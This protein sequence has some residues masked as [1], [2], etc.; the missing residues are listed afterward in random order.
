MHYLSKK[1]IVQFNKETIDAHGGNFNP[2]FN[3]LHEENL[4]YLIEAIHSELFGQ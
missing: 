3:F 4:D 2:P 1:L